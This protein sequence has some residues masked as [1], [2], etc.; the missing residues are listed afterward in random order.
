M[1]C[2]RQLKDLNLHYSLHLF[3]QLKCTSN[4]QE[5]S[6]NY[7]GGGDSHQRDESIGCLHRFLEMMRYLDC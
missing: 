7:S 3:D 5:H 6:E 1:N 2:L 4:D